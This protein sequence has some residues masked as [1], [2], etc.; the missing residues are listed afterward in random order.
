MIIERYVDWAATAPAHMRAEAAGAL[1]RSYLHGDLEPDILEEVEGVL[2]RALDDASIAV[3]CAISDAFASSRHAPTTIVL[4]LA[5]DTPDVATPILARSPVLGEAELIDLVAT[6]GMRTQISIA[7]RR[8]VSE[9]VAAAIAEIAGPE[10]C[11]ALVGNPGA[12]LT[13]RTAARVAARHGA[14]G[15]VREALLS[16]DD[17]GPEIRQIVM[18]AVADTLSSFVSRCGWLGETRAQRAADEACE[19]GAIAIAAD[20]DDAR[21][22]V[23]H[24]A[25]RG[26]FSPSLALRSLLG[27]DTALFEAALSALSG[28]A[29]RRV[30]GFVRDFSGRGFAALYAEAGL[31]KSA[32]P[33]FRA[34]L[35]AQREMGFAGSPRERATLSRRM[36]ERVITAC[37]GA[38]PETATLRALLRRFAAEAMRED[39]RRSYP[40][41]AAAA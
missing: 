28:H 33:A 15:P 4:A 14:D 26:Q 34:A 3:R 6:G 37:D 27:G 19:R 20:A 41:V 39:A 11:E 23:L 9:P 22:F 1:A 13:A 18:R 32:L 30:A 36:V 7:C 8:E 5:N 29:P 12:R 40:M 21:A 17:V 16:R 31:P 10:A 25:E 38:G 35:E 24:L 2:M